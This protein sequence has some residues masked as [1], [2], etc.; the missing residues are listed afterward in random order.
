M[1]RWTIFK[2]QATVL[3]PFYNQNIL[4][5]TSQASFGHIVSKINL[6]CDCH[7]LAVKNLFLRSHLNFYM[8]QI[9]SHFLINLYFLDSNEKTHKIMRVMSKIYL[10]KLRKIYQKQDTNTR[11]PT[12]YILDKEA[13]DIKTNIQKLNLQL[14]IAITKTRCSHNMRNKLLF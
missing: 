7:I 6:F 3:L 14:E 5:H 4:W 1:N 10:H 8:F 11:Q 2:K 9:L 13:Y 12:V